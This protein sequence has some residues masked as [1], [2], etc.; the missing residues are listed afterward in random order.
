MNINLH[1]KLLNKFE[2]KTSHVFILRKPE[3]NKIYTIYE[4][5]GPA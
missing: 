4:Y 5:G 3:R 1:K 2:T